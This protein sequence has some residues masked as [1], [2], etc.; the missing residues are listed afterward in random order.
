MTVHHGLRAA[1]GNVSSGPT[2]YNYTTGSIP[3]WLQQ[4]TRYAPYTGFDANGF[5][6]NG[7]AYFSTNS[8]PI[9]T[10]N[11]AFT[12]TNLDLKFVA[13]KN[14]VCSDHGFCIFKTGTLPTW[15]WGTH[16]SRI[17]FQWNC[18]SPYWYPPSGSSFANSG[19]SS[20]LSYYVH[21]TLD[22]ITGAYHTIIRTGSF[23]GSQ[24]TNISST[25]SDL[26]L[27]NLSGWS[28]GNTYEIGFDADQDSTSY[29]SYF[30]DITITIT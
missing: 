18:S 16:T 9:A 8:Y 17:A 19:A 5:W 4:R 11:L 20:Y 22:L 2:V 27:S 7:N 10:N 14:A 6:I 23:S 21:I 3:S 30:K 1:A 28:S 25:S 15:K 12:G 24:V 26:K 29:K 13:V